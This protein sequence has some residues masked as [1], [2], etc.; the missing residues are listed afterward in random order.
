MCLRPQALPREG[1]ANCSVCCSQF[2]KRVGIGCGKAAC[3]LGELEWY[4]A[5]AIVYCNSGCHFLKIHNVGG[6]HFLWYRNKHLIQQQ[7]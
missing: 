7:T 1:K 6:Q 2:A 3:G 5:Y 4:F